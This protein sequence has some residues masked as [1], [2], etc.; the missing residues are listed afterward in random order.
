M[1]FVL[2][3]NEPTVLEQGG[4]ERL[5]DIEAAADMVRPM[6]ALYVGGMGA[7]GKNFYNDYAVRLG[8]EGSAAAIQDLYLGGKKAEA[9]ATVPDRLVDTV[10]L[11][12][13]PAR[14]RDR[15]EAWKAAAKRGSVGTMILKTDDVAAL[16]LVADCVL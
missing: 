9:A 2:K 4:F 16:R 10:A 12:G 13:P 1:T 3:A 8:Y 5:G 7:R 11:V 15:L 14:I 6:L